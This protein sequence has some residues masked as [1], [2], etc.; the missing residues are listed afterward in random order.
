MKAHAALVARR[1]R[2]AEAPREKEEREEPTSRVRV[3]C[4]GPPAAAAVAVSGG[5]VM[6][7]SATCP[8]RT[9]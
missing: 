6:P 3:S 9:G 5:G 7:A 1:S 8:S 2:A 4:D